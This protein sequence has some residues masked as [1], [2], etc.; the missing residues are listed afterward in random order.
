MV[1][2]LNEAY[3][4]FEY[5]RQLRRDFHR[6]PE[7]GFQEVRT[8][9]TVARE[10]NQL[11]LEVTTG[12]GKTGVVGLLEG[13][14]PGPVVLLRF[15]MDALPIQEETGADYASVNPGLMHAC[16]HDGHTAIGLTVARI[17][18]SQRRSLAGMVKFVFQPAEEGLGGAEAMIVDGVL[19]NPKPDFSLALHL[20][21]YKPVGWLG[22]APGP[23]MAAA[24]LFQMRISGRGGH[25]AAPHLAIDPLVAAAQ[26]IT[27]LQSIVS[28]NVAPLKSA[29]ISVTAVQGG[30]AF[31]VIPS[32]VEMKG[33]IRTFEPQVR[34]LVLERFSQVVTGVAQSMECQAELTVQPVTPAVINDAGVTQRVQAVAERLLPDSQ[35]DADARSMVS[36]DMAEMMQ[37]IPG[38]YFLIGSANAEKGLDAVHHHPRFDFD[39]DSLPSAA[40][41]MASAAADL[42]RI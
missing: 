21:N 3:A 35:V 33:T 6:H 1:D 12:V 41:L 40:A 13:A 9:G 11:G 10:L 15:D 25:G 34:D 36:E 19:T 22:I 28:R 2:F 30:E 38:C 17:L 14:Q 23:L 27:A 20:W 29:V 37:D 18:E 24:E 39:E 5:T 26:I 32:T 7:L 8:A 4:L 16:G 42:L 31:N